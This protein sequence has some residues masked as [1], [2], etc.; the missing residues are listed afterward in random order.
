MAV[1][2][3]LRGVNEMLGVGCR[4][5]QP[6]L[7]FDDVLTPVF[8][9]VYVIV[10][11]CHILESVL[12]PLPKSLIIRHVIRELLDAI[13]VFEPWDTH[14]GVFFLQHV[15]IV[16]LDVNLLDPTLDILVL[17]TGRELVVGKILLSCLKVT[18]SIAFPCLSNVINQRSAGTMVYFIQRERRWLWSGL[19]VCDVS[20]LF[21][22]G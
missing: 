4:P 15:V 9:M 1:K 19:R 3:T 2:A 11:P 6:S 20:N 5:Y 18:L 10:I 22:V 13:T 12:F 21:K 8:D 14:S 7:P 16:R 17:S